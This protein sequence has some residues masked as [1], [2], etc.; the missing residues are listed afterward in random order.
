MIVLF[1]R[2]RPF[3]LTLLLDPVW[4][5]VDADWTF[6]EASEDDR[7]IMFHVRGE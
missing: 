2:R 3:Q 1:Y 6:L 5:G 7:P 4:V